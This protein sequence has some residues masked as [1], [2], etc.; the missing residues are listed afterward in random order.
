M[1]GFGVAAAAAGNAVVAADTPNLDRLFARVPLRTTLAAPGSPSG[2]PRDRWAT[3]RSATSTSAPAASSTRS[4]R[5]STSRSRT[6]P[7]STTPC[8]PRRSTPRSPPGE[9]STSWASLSD[10]GVHSHQRA[11]LRAAR[12]GACARG[13]SRVYVHGFLDGRDV[14]PQSGLGYVRALEGVL[15]RAR[16]G[17]DRD[18]HGPLLRHGPGQPLGPRRAGVAGARARRRRAR[19]RPPSR[20]STPPTPPA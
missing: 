3:P 16:R 13:A 10:G 11:P 12:D 9:R 8:S 15:A 1:D 18:G 6:A 5:A 4:S 2:C 14:P 20:R 19:R 17:R 7:S